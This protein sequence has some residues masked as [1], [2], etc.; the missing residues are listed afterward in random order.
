[1]NVL[2]SAERK[3]E[4]LVEGVFGRAFKASVQPVELAHKLAKEMGDHKTLGVSSVFVPNEYEVY[5]GGD[6]HEK[7]S[8]LGDALKT[9]LANYLTAFARREG[10]TMVAAP[11]IELKRDDDL[12]TG[13]FGIATRT[14]SVDDAAAQVA[15]APGAARP[16]PAA[17][18]AAAAAAA[19]A[20]GTSLAPPA[21]ASP[22]QTVLYERPPAPAVRYAV[23]G[24]GIDVELTNAVNLIGRSRRCDIVL[25]D[26]NVSRQHAELRLTGSQV[27]LRDLGST[28][29]TRVNRRAVTQAVLRPGDRIEVGTTELLFERR[30]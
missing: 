4:G 27:V 2:K 26:P 10:W 20:P 13:E 14:V 24:P 6:D 17:P 7:L 28:N 3:L 22:A 23:R 29:G 21:G 11:R 5:L 30:A 9:E 16:A 15:A 19:A 8:S 12:R 18:V 1:M 25:T